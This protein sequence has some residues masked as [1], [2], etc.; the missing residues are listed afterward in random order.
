MKFE[1]LTRP[2][3][4]V[5]TTREFA[6]ESS[7]STA[8]AARQLGSA[9]ERGALV[10]I[11]RG[12]WANPSHPSFHPFACVP[13][14]LGRE[15]GY[16]SFLTALHLHGVV[17]QIPRAMQIA[18]TGHGRRLATP[19]GDYELFRV[20]PAMMQAGVVWSDTRVPYRIATAEKAL[21]DT[22]YI[23]M[24]RGR[25]FRSLPELELDGV[26]VRRFR[27]LLATVG[28]PRVVGALERRFDELR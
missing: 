17:S 24:R 15:Q 28:D 19:V 3:F 11:T 5:F 12:V 23:S 7:I 26:S 21:L 6:I 22:L 9:A 18:T 2:D 10:R 16:V 8:S 1:L 20:V 25:R 27:G 14:I 4:A 13:K